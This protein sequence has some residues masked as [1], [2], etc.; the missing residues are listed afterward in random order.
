MKYGVQVWIAAAVLAVARCGAQ[1]VKPLPIHSPVQDKGFYLLSLLQQ[2][3]AVRGRLMGDARLGEIAA[4]RGRALVEAQK[5]CKGDAVCTL[6]PVLWTD[7]EIHAVSLALAALAERDSTVRELV[8][9]ALRPSGAYVLFA[10]Q[11]DGELLANAW[12]VC[13]RGLNDV[14]AVYGEGQPPRYPLIDSISFD[15]KPGEF[16]QDVMQMAKQTTELDAEKELFFEPALKTALQL[17]TLNHRDE[18][19]R[20]EP[21]ERGVNRA[22]V[23]AVGKTKWPQFPYTVIVVPGAGGTD[24][25]TPLSAA[26]HKRCEL[27]AEAYRAGKAPFVLVSGGYV[28]PSQT[29][30]AEA[31]EMKRALIDDFHLP[32]SAVLVDPH[33]RHTTTNMRNA[34]REI[35]R[36]GLP[37]DKPAL[38]VSDESQTA[39]IASEIFADRNLK[40]LGYVPYKIVGKLSSTMLAFLPAV[41]SLQQ[42]PIEPLDP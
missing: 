31:I 40:E 39:Y 12:E 34:A 3:E 26:G 30:F 14:V 28:H 8:D 21:M 36:Y 25:T 42:D 2:D 22:A 33:A 41:E 23:E 7:E 38:M 20:F 1:E 32:E 27:A 11:P 37:M 35:F 19:G 5:A 29:P 13:A 15:V 9:R 10:K 24:K 17:L 4:E 18:A 6:K 16:Q